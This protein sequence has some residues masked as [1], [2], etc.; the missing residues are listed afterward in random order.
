MT[1]QGYAPE[2]AGHGTVASTAAI[3]R[4]SVAESGIEEVLDAKD[5]TYVAIVGTGRG[6]WRRLGTAVA[7]CATE[8]SGTAELCCMRCGRAGR[9]LRGEEP[10]EGDG[11]KAGLDSS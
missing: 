7:G 9:L 2:D 11:R 3:A 10:D 6:L 4:Q 1:H 8:D 5:G